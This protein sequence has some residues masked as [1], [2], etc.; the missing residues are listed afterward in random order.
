MYHKLLCMV[1]VSFA[2]TDGVRP[3]DYFAEGFDLYESGDRTR[4]KIYFEEGLRQD[5]KSGL[6]NFFLAKILEEQGD[7]RSAYRHYR[8]SLPNLPD[9]TVEGRE[10]RVNMQIVGEAAFAKRAESIEHIKK[11]PDYYFLFSSAT[12]HFCLRAFKYA[13]NT[14][15][16][17][18]NFTTGSATVVLFA[19]N[20]KS[21]NV[22]KSIADYRMR[23]TSTDEIQLV[24]GGA[25]EMVEKYVPTLTIF[26]RSG[27]YE[28]ASKNLIESRRNGELYI[29][30]AH[31][32]KK[33]TC[34]SRSG[35]SPPI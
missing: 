33:N 11:W 23:W 12:H 22:Q 16:S 3:Q 10:A 27:G 19:M 34:W 29:D 32:D 14:E 24:A 8:Q 30:G 15:S 6:G 1:I 18:R 20:R 28:F 5:P 25:N 4:A 7:L 17:E 9:T 31:Y 13:Y 2:M 21:G 26:P 35:Y